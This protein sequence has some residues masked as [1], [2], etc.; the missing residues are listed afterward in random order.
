MGRGVRCQVHKHEYLVPEEHHHLRPRARGGTNAADNMVWLCANAHGD[1][2]YY[3]DLIED[4]RGPDNVPFTIGKHY[5]PAVRQYAVKGWAAYAEEFLA[6]TWD[7]HAFLWSTSG[8]PRE[9]LAD[10]VPPYGTAVARGEADQWLNVAALT[11][12]ATERRVKRGSQ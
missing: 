7:R 8:Q 3:L 4:H 11:F 2:H 1:V 12:I 9:D 5:S 10:R 6:G